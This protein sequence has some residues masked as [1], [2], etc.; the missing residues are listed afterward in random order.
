MTEREIE[1]E[2]ELRKILQYVLAEYDEELYCKN[3][4]DTGREYRECN[5]GLRGCK[6]C[7]KCE[8]DLSFIKK[9]YGII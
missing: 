1:L 2:K 4:K 8:L 7:D 3:S 9:V 5:L 6:T